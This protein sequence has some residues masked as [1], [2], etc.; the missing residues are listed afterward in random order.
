MKTKPKGNEF[1]V[2]CLM[3]GKDFHADK[4]ATCG[5]RINGEAICDSAKLQREID[6]RLTGK[7]EPSNLEI[8]TPDKKT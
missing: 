1:I 2:H 3:C 4:T 6:A 8:N 7:T 5:G